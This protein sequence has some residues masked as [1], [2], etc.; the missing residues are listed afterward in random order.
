MDP[1][2]RTVLDQFLE[3]CRVDLR[4]GPRTV[5][6]HKYVIKRLLAQNP[7]PTTQDIR[8]FLGRI[9]NPSTYNNYLKSLRVF[10][11]DF[12]R[13][14]G[15]VWSF[16]FAR[17]QGL[18]PRLYS[19]KDLQA[20]YAALEGHKERA[21]FLMYASSGR[22][23]GEVLDL[24]VD[25]VDL[26]TRAILPNKMSATKRTWYSFFNEECLEELKAYLKE[27]RRDTRRSNRLFPLSKPNLY[28]LFRI[29]QHKTGLK[30][31]P[32]SLRFW[33]ANE[34]ARLSVSDRF[35]NTFQGRVP[36]SVLARHY[37]DYSLENLKAVY[38]KAGLKVLLS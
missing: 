17:D 10:Y 13:Q 32:Q 6:R 4:Q 16:R 11:R 30:I 5:E 20:F 25:Q 2:I 23:M 34:M 28:A 8:S 24:L 19:K 36:R 3:Y 1:A 35:I 29:A 18:L 15:L 14:P 22:R 38:D 7:N 33:F 37:T 9:E 26:E 31:T 12:K 21:I 27:E